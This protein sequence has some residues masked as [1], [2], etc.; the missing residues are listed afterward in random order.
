M[1]RIVVNAFAVIGFVAACIQIWQWGNTP[2]TEVSAVAIYKTAPSIP[3]FAAQLQGIP[4]I[5]PAARERGRASVRPSLRREPSLAE[6][7]EG[8]DC[9]GLLTPYLEGLSQATVSHA[10][11]FGWFITVTNNG[12]VTAT[13]VALHVPG[14]V[15]A[16]LLSPGATQSTIIRGSPEPRSFDDP[17]EDVNV[18]TLQPKQSASIWIWTS[19]P[20][21]PISSSQ[22]TLTHDH[23]SGS[24]AVFE[25]VIAR[26]PW[27]YLLLVVVVLGAGIVAGFY[28]QK[29]RATW[30]SD[31]SDAATRPPARHG[32]V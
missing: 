12:T 26:P 16:Y 31:A 20:T 11:S 28:T 23:G 9:M 19:Y 10:F 30:I 25:P 5:I 15:E 18:G 29:I 14:F 2:S 4:K 17:L 6:P 3:E 13:T 27:A 21:G 1:K 24:V 32:A 7:M 8:D 22:I